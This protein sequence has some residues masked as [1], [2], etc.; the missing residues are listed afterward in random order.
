MSLLT[1]LFTMIDGLFVDQMQEE[2]QEAE[3]LN[4]SITYANM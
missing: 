1:R 4:V 2:Q 3:D